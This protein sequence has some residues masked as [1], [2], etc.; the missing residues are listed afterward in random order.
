MEMLP[1]FT[2]ILHVQNI[3]LPEHLLAVLEELNIFSKKDLSSISHK[4]RGHRMFIGI[5]KL[6]ALIDMACQMEEQDQVV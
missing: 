6:L 3:S 5:K 1:A 4:I 2:A